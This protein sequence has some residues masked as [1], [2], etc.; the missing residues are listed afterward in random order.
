MRKFILSICFLTLTFYSGAQQL[1]TA[2]VG[3]AYTNYTGIDYLFVFNGITASNEVITYNGKLTSDSI[4]TWEKFDGTF[5]AQQSSFSPENNTGYVLKVNGKIKTTC[6]VI[7]Y[8]KYVPTSAA[9]IEPENNPS[10]QCQNL[11]L[12][13]SNVPLM[14]YTPYG[15][16]V[17]KNITRKFN[18][19]Y[20][21]RKWDGSAYSDSLAIV[22]VT[23]PTTKVTVP[24]PYCNTKFK[25]SGDQ[26]ADDLKISFDSIKSSIY[27]TNAVICKATSIVAIRLATNE[28]ERPS[29]ASQLTGS[30]P[31]DMQFICTDN[32][33]DNLFYNWNIYKG[34][35]LIVNRKDKDHRYTF[36]EAGTYKVILTVSSSV[37]SYSDS[38]TVTVRESDIVA[39]N[40]FTPNG[41]GVNDE[42]RVGYKSIISFQ[43][44]VYNR[45]GRQVYMWTDPTKGWD[46]K[47][48]G[49]DATPGPYF[50]VIKAK[51]SDFDPS[52]TPNALTHLRTGEYLLKGDINL[53]RGVK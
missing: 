12:L 46:G 13:I 47:I 45:W 20:T 10:A 1:L 37:C 44:W 22:P 9:S 21:T 27:N 23:F 33:L 43:C 35:N 5:V 17:S 25:L 18:I 26:F 28:A 11:N 51:G 30:A 19:E 41:D 39:P 40:V 36:T 24:V 2:N 42:F 50:Y 3:V 6:W 53:L 8:Q 29:L 31:L 48:N 7:D 14:T 15:T 38:L 16:T 34:S 32:K 4:V 52:S 49:K